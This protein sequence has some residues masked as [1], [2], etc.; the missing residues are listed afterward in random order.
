M[1]AKIKKNKYHDIR[2]LF[3][4]EYF[5]S[6]FIK[7]NIHL[8]LSP[9]TN[10]YDPD[11]KKDINTS[12]KISSNNLSSKENKMSQI[13][14]ISKNKSNINYSKLIKNDKNIK[15]KKI[16]IKQLINK[17]SN[18]DISPYNN[19]LSISH[20]QHDTDRNIIEKN[21]N[22]SNDDYL[23]NKIINKINENQANIKLKSN[24]RN[25]NNKN[26]KKNKNNNKKILCNSLFK[27]EK[28]SKNKLKNN[29]NENRNLL[30]NKKSKKILNLN[31]ININESRKYNKI[32]N[33]KESLDKK[34]IYLNTIEPN[35]VKKIKINNNNLTD[36][37]KINENKSFNSLNKNKFSLTKNKN[38]KNYKNALKKKVIYN[39]FNSTNNSSTL[40]SQIF[41]NS[42]LYTERNKK[43]KNNMGVKNIKNNINIKG[44]INNNYCFKN[45]SIDINNNTNFKVNIN[46]YCAKNK[47]IDINNT[48]NFYKNKFLILLREEREKLRKIE[49][50]KHMEEIEMNS[51]KRIQKYIELFNTLNNSFSDIKNLIEQIEKEDLL[52]D[53]TQKFN[54]D[55]S[56]ESIANKEN[57]YSISIEQRFKSILSN[58]L[59]NNING[60]NKSFSENTS[61]IINNDFTFEED[62]KDIFLKSIDIKT[63]S[64]LEKNKN[65]TNTKNIVKKNEDNCFIF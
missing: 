11:T 7:P 53:I 64:V 16:L 43:I 38:N 20:R 63:N 51:N 59:F 33:N 35:V 26:I 21:P 41:Q 31:E 25:N 6:Y 61:S 65:I 36:L 46:N 32:N 22:I 2:N 52:K 34:K 29:K 23:Y 14:R 19:S 10:R 15:K 49:F 55:M 30:I 47:S 18:N 54:D 12:K 37:K 50:K 4:K 48:S 1:N 45:K 39:L 17:S 27:A 57:N 28:G 58:G 56:Y 24:N 40:Y 62:K 13:I 42:Q 9:S 5:K 44:N 60:K 3:G 8:S